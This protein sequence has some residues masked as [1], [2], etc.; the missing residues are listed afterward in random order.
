MLA[1]EPKQPPE[2]LGWR[3]DV[4]RQIGQTVHRVV[5]EEV[6][7]EDLVG[8][9]PMVEVPG[10]SFDVGDVLAGLNAQVAPLARAK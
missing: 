1:F 8:L 2:R 3:K 10:E 5:K 6:P 9:G 7:A 4:F